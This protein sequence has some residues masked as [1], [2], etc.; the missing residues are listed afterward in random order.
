MGSGPFSLCNVRR[1]GRLQKSLTCDAC[2]RLA[3]KG[4]QDP[5]CAENYT[6]AGETCCHAL[7]GEKGADGKVRCTRVQ[8]TCIRGHPHPDLK[9]N[10]GCK[11]DEQCDE[12]RGQESPS[13]P[14][15]PPKHESSQPPTPNRYPEESS[16][17]WDN[18]PSQPTTPGRYPQESTTPGRYHQESTTPG[19][20]HQES[21]TPGRYHQESTTPGRYHQESTTPGRYH[22]ESTT[23]NRYPEEST[24]DS[25]ES[26]LKVSQGVSTPSIPTRWE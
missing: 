23:P 16:T 20:Y 17:R 22:Q 11:G 13:T 21:T 25:R 18:E 26:Y 24:N 4:C 14:S 19:R 8:D 9:L 7:E 12:C 5:W 10:G 15:T 3:S 6:K 2:R 1:G